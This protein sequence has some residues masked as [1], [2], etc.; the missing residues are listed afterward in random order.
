MGS[1]RE[2]RSAPYFSFADAFNTK[3]PYYLS[4][5][6]TEEQYWDRDCSL[7]IAYREADK[8]RRER[9]NQDAW[10]QGMYVYDAIMRLS[11]ILH[12][13][14]KKG[15]KPQP[16]VDAPYPI[17]EEGREEAE[18]RKE[19]AMADKGKRFMEAFMV[20]NNPKLEERK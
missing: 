8:I 11:P 12:A 20:K 6:M 16:Y 19:K 5:G 4:I 15:T 14:A 10:L 9:A 1:E 2:S 7:T 3:F 13:F 17:S 18:V